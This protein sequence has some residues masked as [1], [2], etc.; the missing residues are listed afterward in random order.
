MSGY[1]TETVYN[2]TF[3]TLMGYDSKLLRDNRSK[4]MLDIVMNS[5]LFDYS[6]MGLGEIGKI[7]TMDNWGSFMYESVVDTYKRS[8]MTALK[9]I[10]RNFE[11]IE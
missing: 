2:T 6:I 5:R 9:K 3:E 10:V 7:Y 1:S 4:D 11:A 8:A